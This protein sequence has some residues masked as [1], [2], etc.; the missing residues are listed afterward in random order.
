[1]IVNEDFRGKELGKWLMECLINHP[2]I[3]N[4]V[5]HLATRDAHG[6]YERYGFNRNETMKRL[7]DS[8][9]EEK[10]KLR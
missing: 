5:Q 6:L 8:N 4:T 1:V 7:P 2:R 9:I 10:F 3:V